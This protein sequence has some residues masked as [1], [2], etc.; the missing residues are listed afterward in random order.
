MKKILL[1][2]ACVLPMLANAQY[3]FDALQYSSS[4]LRGTSRFVSMGGAFSALGGDISTLNQNP[5]G[6][7][8]YRSSD[9]GFSFGLDMNSSRPEGVTA[10]N[11]TK[12]VVNN[13]GYV[14]SLKIGSTLKYFNWGFSYTR[15]NT[16]NRR[17]MGGLLGIP[18]SITNFMADLATS[19][20]VEPSKLYMNHEYDYSPFSNTSYAYNVL[21]YNCGV[22]IPTGGTNYT[23][24]GLNGTSGYAEY[25]VDEW[26]ETDQYNI[27][28]G[29]NVQDVVYWGMSLGITSLDYHYYNY[30]GEQL[31][32]TEVLDDPGDIATIV[33]GNTTF[34][35]VN[36]S[37]T[38]GNGYNFKL[39]LIFKPVNALRIGLAFHTP[40]FYDM[41]DVWDA[42]MSAEFYGDEIEKGS[43][44]KNFSSAVNEYRYKIRTPW[45]FMGGIAGVIGS[46]AIISAD[47]EYVDNESMK[48]LDNAGRVEPGS[49]EEMKTYLKPTHIMRVGAEYRIN[50]SWSLRAGYQHQTSQVE[51]DVEDNKLFVTTS[52]YNPSYKFD[53]S[54]DYITCGV[55]FH[56]RSFYLDLA[57]LHRTRKSE[58][59][60]FSPIEYV[61]ESGNRAIDEGIYTAVKDNSNRLSCTIGFRF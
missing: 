1:V 25:E 28:L 39:G 57:Y 15:N 51:K 50:N 60:A 16:F 41:K 2:V 52:G 19:E 4:E 58:Y 47:Y 44:T 43:Y 53:K 18:T 36:N 9:I 14:G 35:L 42:N 40:T 48:I 26:G 59:H 46:K 29:G 38:T 12:V 6:I 55:G 3:T 27:S 10:T 17:Y 37:R 34:G 33:K 11:Q 21:G 23:G 32:N 13:V 61:N 8:V 5:G 49:E 20:G 45:R 56:Y 24:L 54:Q 22:I 7:G 30:Y 31:E